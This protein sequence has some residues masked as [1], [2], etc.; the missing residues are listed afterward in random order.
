[1]L[2]IKSTKNY[3][4]VTVSGDINDLSRLVDA[5][6]EITVDEY[7]KHTAYINISIRV[8]GLCYDVRH[9]MQGDREVELFENGIDEY[10]MKYHSL[11]APRHNVYYSCNCLYP[12]MF[13]IM[14]A[15]NQLVKLRVKELAK[16]KYGY[17]TLHHNA[18]WD[19]TIAVV[20]NFQAEFT[21]CVRALFSESKFSRWLKL[22]NDDSI[23]IQDIAGQYVDVCNIKY[24]N[25]SKEQ[26]LKNLSKIAKRIAEFNSDEE[27][28]K[29]KRVVSKAARQ[30]G[31]DESSINLKSIEYPEEIAW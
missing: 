19:D 2:T 24:L 26:R 20:R 12:E 27:H 6:H 18:V 8:L 17:N 7:S 4:G 10:I 28:Q 11:I 31:C 9:A 16:S 21:R 22:M 1:M 3:A 30:Y 29:I 15:L 13:V 25:M 23:N 14:L 5:F